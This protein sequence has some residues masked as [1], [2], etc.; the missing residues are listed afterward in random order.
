M[1]WTKKNIPDQTGKTVIVTGANTGIGFETALGLYEAGAQVILACRNRYSGEEA[2]RAISRAK[3][4]GSVEFALLDLSSLSSVRQFAASFRENHS[5]LNL[6]INNAGIMTPPAAKTAEGYESQFGV[7]FLAHFALTGHLYDLLNATPGSRIVTVSS[8]A[9]HYGAINFDNLKLELPYDPFREY[10]QSKLA[11]LLFT[12][13]LQRRITAAG[14]PSIS[15][16]THPG[17]T[18]SSLSRYMTAEAIQGAIDTFGALMETAQGAL[19]VLYAA[20]AAD[21][22]PGGFYGPDSD[23]GLRGYPILTDMGENARD[24]ITAQKLWNTAEL[25]AKV[26]FQI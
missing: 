12:I 11:D 7:N 15:V 16:A 10:C 21:V 18:K 17:V 25:A 26:N 3:G 9:Y 24:E 19:P 20:V 6:L 23:S 8:L 4:T 14:E 1:I 2:C 5:Q 22:M 13:E